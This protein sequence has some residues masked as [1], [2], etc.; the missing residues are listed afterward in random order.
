M[1]NCITF[2]L[3][4]KTKL[5]GKIEIHSWSG[6]WRR[7]EWPVLPHLALKLE[8]GTLVHYKAHA[9]NLPLL[10]MWNFDGDVVFEKR[11]NRD[12]LRKNS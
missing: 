10:K 9:K 2:V 12:Q 11:K 7:Q 1:R 6:A 8:D 3:Y 5:K 4:A